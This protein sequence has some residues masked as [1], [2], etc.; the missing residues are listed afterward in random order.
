M[1]GGPEDHEGADHERTV[2]VREGEPQIRMETLLRLQ[3][4]LMDFPF[5]PPKACTMRTALKPS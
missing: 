5:L 4:K 3:M 2:H 1:R